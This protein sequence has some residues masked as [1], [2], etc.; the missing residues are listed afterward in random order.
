MNV[1]IASVTPRKILDS[2]GEWTIEVLIKLSN[3]LQTKAS[4]PQGKSK[5]SYEASYVPVDR[6]IDIVKNVI[7]PNIKGRKLNEQK[8]FDT[9]LINLDGTENKSRLGANSTLGLSLVYARASALLNNIPLWSYIQNIYGLKVT[10]KPYL[11]VNLINGG[12]HAGN[13][14]NFQEYMI[15]PQTQS[16]FVSVEASVAIYQGMKKFLIEHLGASASNLGDEGGCAPYFPN[17]LAPFEILEKVIQRQNLPL[18][19]QF[20][21]DAA[22]N[23]I[24][25][26]PAD[27]TNSYKTMIEKFNLFYLEDPY[28]E[29]DFKNFANLLKKS[30]S[31][32]IICGD[33]L[34]AT[35]I[36][37]IKMACEKK[38]IN[39]VVI[40]PNQI[41]TLSETLDAV[42]LARKCKYSCVVSH[43]SGE[44]NDDFIVDFAHGIGADGIKIGAPARGERVA[45]F[46][47]F[48]EIEEEQLR[49]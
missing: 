38:S 48:L 30:K 28:G 40:K 37:R 10:R 12:L 39:G 20:G 7:E 3:G 47:R 4:V 23:N 21:L 46:N 27:L 24:K 26:D 17:V 31:S 8:A 13:N 1:T 5:G 43:R 36:F 16:Y 14:L 35:N 49:R 41:G 2:R 29:N 34:T 18:K 22:A 9:L 45:K 11:Y 6:A 33:D 32:V 15:I 42:K 44:T 19:M 25:K